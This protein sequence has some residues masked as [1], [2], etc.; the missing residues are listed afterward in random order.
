MNVFVKNKELTIRR[1]VNADIDNLFSY[2]Q[3]L[4]AETRSKF[5]PHLF[6]RESIEKFYKDSSNMAYLV[7]DCECDEI[8]AYSIVKTGIVDCDF[9][10]FRSYGL[11]LNNASD[12]TFA[13]S[14]ADGWQSCGIGS[15]MLQF[16]LHELKQADVN[17]LFLWGGV[18]SKNKKAVN[19]YKKFG[20][21]T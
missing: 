14:V 4:S 20:F 16:I 7:F 13:P 9:E 12:Y 8:V 6:D 11:N 10:R 15:I 19:Y 3:K 1:F 18:Q 17:R 2:L 5:A 21:R